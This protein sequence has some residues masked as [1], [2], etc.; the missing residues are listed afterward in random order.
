MRANR[1]VRGSGP[2]LDGCASTP[3]ARPLQ[4]GSGSGGDDSMRQRLTRHRPG[5]NM[6]R[7]QLPAAAIALSV[8]LVSTAAAGTLVLPS[9]LSVPDGFRLIADYGSYRLVEG[10]LAQA[11]AGA[12]EL[13][14]PHWL[15]FDFVPVAMRHL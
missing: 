6:R 3:D 13:D 10:E 1:A 14:D 4:N 2:P 8:S 12:W 7:I 11:P 15:G 5:T 9:S